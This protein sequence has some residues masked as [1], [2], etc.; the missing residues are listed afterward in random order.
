MG[1]HVYEIA[2]PAGTTLGDDH[3]GTGLHRV[4]CIPGAGAAHRETPR[5]AAESG[6]RLGGD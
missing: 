5:R 4:A 3:A 1:G 2:G 6:Q